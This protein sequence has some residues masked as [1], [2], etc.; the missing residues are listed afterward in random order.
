MPR[1][2]APPSSAAEGGGGE[3]DLMHSTLSRA[4]IPHDRQAPD[5]GKWKR[6]FS[7]SRKKR[8]SKGDA[9]LSSTSSSLTGREHSRSLEIE[10]KTSSKPS[11]RPRSGTS[12]RTSEFFESSDEEEDE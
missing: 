11:Y 9:D 5:Q 10:P 6:I 3:S 4:T 2:P 7:F 1:P 12:R 8:K